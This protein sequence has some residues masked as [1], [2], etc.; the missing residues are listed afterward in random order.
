MHFKVEQEH[1]RFM[2]ALQPV[3]D[4][5]GPKIVVTDSQV[6]HPLLDANGQAAGWQSSVT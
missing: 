6:S 3:L 1:R 5:E 2:R 4:H